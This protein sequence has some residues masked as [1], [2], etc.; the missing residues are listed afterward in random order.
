MTDKDENRQ[1]ISLESLTDEEAIFKAVRNKCIQSPFTIIPLALAGG[2]LLLTGA[3]SWGFFGVFAAVVLGVVGAA[4]FVYNMWIRGETLTKRHIR[5]MMEELK[6]DRR[7][8]LAEVAE[9]CRELGFTEAAKEAVELS[10]AY[11]QYT[12]FLETRA[13]AKLGNA[14]GQRLGLAESARKAGVEHLRQAAEIHSA[15][16]GINITML[17]HE[18]AG[19]TDERLKADTNHTVLDS[20]ISAH[21]QQINRYEQLTAKRDE[22]IARSNELEA[23]LKSAYMSDAGRSDLA[24]DESSD[25]LA[26]RL[27]SVVA[28]AEAAETDMKEFLR[29]VRNETS[30]IL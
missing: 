2:I 11:S 3:F 14:V 23:A 21:T 13:G 12:E 7:T 19:W 26:T 17:R 29:N 1:K 16:T 30:T 22:L 4:A 28:A 10:D 20:K 27:S 9:M 8:A 24:L 18:L 25:N 5:W 6:Q 15:L